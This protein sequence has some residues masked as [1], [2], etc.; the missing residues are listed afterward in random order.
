MAAKVEE[1]FRKAD[2]IAQHFIDIQQKRKPDPADCKVHH[3]VFLYSRR[4]K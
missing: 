2:M 4:S 1:S 3:V